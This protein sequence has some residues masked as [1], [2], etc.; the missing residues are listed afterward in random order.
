MLA[1]G[2]TCAAGCVDTTSGPTTRPV[3]MRQRQDAA[4]RDPF[5]YKLTDDDFPSV[6]GGGTNQLDRNALKRDVDSFWNP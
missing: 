6:S 1:A 2:F 5:G 4:V 3:S